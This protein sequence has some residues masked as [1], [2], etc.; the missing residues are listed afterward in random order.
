MILLISTESNERFSVGIAD[1]SGLKKYKTESKRFQ[2]SE[3]LL[4]TI[5]QLVGADLNVLEKIFVIKGP[6]AF[7]AL[8]TGVAIANSLAY[9]LD[10]LITG[11]LLQQGFAN[12]KEKLEWLLEQ[13]NKK[14]GEKI[15]VPEYGKAPNIGR[16]S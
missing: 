9:G 6:G 1:K 16:K 2:L 4:K 13:G 11:V 15:I 7:S 12:E 3:L 8:R 5:K 14:E 10:I